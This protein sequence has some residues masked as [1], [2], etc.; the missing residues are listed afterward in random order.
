[1]NLL[2]GVRILDLSR[3]LPGPYC[4]RL[5]ADL[6]AEVIKV[7]E[8]GRGDYI[9]SL[10][11]FEN[12]VSVAFE[13]LNRGKKSIALNL[14]TEQGQEILQK[15]AA[16]ADVLLESYRPGT[17]KKLGCDFESIRRVNQRIVYC[18]L[19]AFGQTGPYKDLPGHDINCLAL[20]G[21]L[22]LNGKDEPVVPALQV[23]DLAGGMLAALTIMT[24]LFAR[25]KRNEAQYIDVSMLDVLLSWLILPLA[26]HMGGNASMLAGE[27]P[28]Y[29]LYRTLDSRF[30]AVGAIEPQFWEELCKLINRPDLT[31]D[32][33]SSGPRRKEV[34]EAVQSALAR[35]TSQDWFRMMCEHELPCTPFLTL[36][37]VLK[38]PHVRERHMLLAKDQ[39]GSRLTYVGSPCKIAG[40][41][42]INLISSP[43]LG[44]H[45][46]ELLK[47]I[48]YSQS[49]I[50]HLVETGILQQSPA[51]RS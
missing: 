48:G 18:S 6:G 35:K 43:E 9:R 44:Q 42:E 33:Y 37:E 15:L 34:V 29:R 41:D 46:T 24:A 4:T 22:S 5:L 28:F 11:P 49:E 8:P 30:L 7:E 50:Q 10:A 12:G 27:L 26:L 13:L 32:Q 25:R 51:K 31:P 20:S 40:L 39:T 17:A 21:F 47:E 1:M 16:E 14:E 38:D 2:D 19:T 3:L 36:D 45:S 23:G